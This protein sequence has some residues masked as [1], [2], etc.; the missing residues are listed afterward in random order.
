M[1]R[2]S[3]PGRIFHEIFGLI[4]SDPSPSVQDDL[5]P[6]AYRR[7][8][9][10]GRS[11]WLTS[12]Y[13]YSSPPLVSPRLE[14]LRFATNL[15]T[16]S[17]LLRQFKGAYEIDPLGT[18]TQPHGVNGVWE[19]MG[20]RQTEN[21]PSRIPKGGWKVMLYSYRRRKLVS[22][23]VARSTLGKSEVEHSGDA[24]IGRA[25]LR[26]AAQRLY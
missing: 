8:Q 26:P 15:R 22:C 1:V 5:I 19:C 6:A 20:K 23:Q 13:R 9:D 18:A 11:M 12:R 2:K 4:R 14:S 24:V 21:L 17:R 25:P 7:G 16:P 3:R 10:C